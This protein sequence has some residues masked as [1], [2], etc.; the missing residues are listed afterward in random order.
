MSHAVR[1]IAI[2]SSAKA[3]QE[4]KGVY[5]IWQDVKG[6]RRFKRLIFAKY[7]RVTKETDLTKEALRYSSLNPIFDWVCFTHLLV[8]AVLR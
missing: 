3:A 2:R 4:K 5:F 6:H 8:L 1:D 7:R